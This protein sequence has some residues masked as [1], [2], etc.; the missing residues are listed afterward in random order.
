M[1]R[2]AVYNMMI[3]RAPAIAAPALLIFS[4]LFHQRHADDILRSRRAI[5]FHAAAAYAIMP[6]PCLRQRC[7]QSG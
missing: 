6:S 1:P 7:L 4:R 5:D 3:E 2:G